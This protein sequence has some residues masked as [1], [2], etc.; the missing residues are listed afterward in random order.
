M[1]ICSHS[2]AVAQMNNKLQ[3]FVSAISKVKRPPD[4]TSLAVHC[5]AS[6][7]GRKGGQATRTRKKAPEPATN[8]VERLSSS[9]VSTAS[10]SLAIGEMNNSTM[11]NLTANY[12]YGSSLYCQPSYK[13]F[14]SYPGSYWMNPYYPECSP[15][16]CS[17]VTRYTF[18]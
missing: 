4:F 18:Y 10:T 9:V 11:L 15:G 17:Y 7:R 5:M 3:Q 14:S 16:S 8:R 1:G 13:C 12:P 2:V 6:G